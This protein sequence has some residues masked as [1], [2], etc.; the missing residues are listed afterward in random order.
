MDQTGIIAL[1]IITVSVCLNCLFALMIVLHRRR[2]VTLHNSELPRYPKV[3]IFL[4]LRNLDDGLEKNISSLLSSRYPAFDVFFA[5]D[6]MNEPC[7]PVIK[8]VIAQ[9]PGIHSTIVP[10]G[11]CESGNPKIHKLSRLEKM[12]DASLFW[13]L[14]SDIRVSPDTLASLVLE[15]LESGA[16]IVFCPIRCSGAATFGSLLEMSY[17]NFFLSGSIITVWKLFRQRVVVGKSMLI[18][19]RALGNFGGFTYFSDVLAEDHWL[20]EAFHKAGFIVRCNYTWVNNIKETTTIENFFGRISRW[21]KLRFCLAPRVYL[22]E[23]LFNP[24]GL[25]LL[26]VPL[27]KAL[28]IPVIGAIIL[29]RISAEYAVFFAVNSESGPRRAFL[30]RGLAPA[31]VCKD[32]MMLFVYVVPFFNRRVTWRGRKIKIRKDTR[33]I[34]KK[35]EA[36]FESLSDRNS[37]VVTVLMGLGHLR[38]AYPLLRMN[39]G[40]MIPY[41]SKFCTPS[42]EYG[43]WRDIRKSYYLISRAGEMPV[44]GKMLLRVLDM[45]QRIEPYHSF[46]DQRKPGFSARYLDY[47]IGRRGLCTGLVATLAELRGPVI[48]TYFAT[49]IAADKAFAH[50]PG[51]KNYLIICD[52]DFNRAWV[53]KDP[54]RSTLR[55]CVPCYW[56]RR[57]LIAYGVPE[58]NIYTT[59]FPLPVENIGSEDSLYILKSDVRERLRRLDPENRFFPVHEAD[60]SHWLGRTKAPLEHDAA[61]TVMFAVGG[62]GAQYRLAHTILDRLSGPV[63]KGKIRLIISTGIRKNIFASIM[64]RVHRL[65]LYDE[66]DKNL[67]LVFDTD[68]FGY[69]DKFNRCLRRTDVL[70]TKPSE[71]VFYAGLGIPVLMAPPIGAHEELNGKWL[72]KIHAGIEPLGPAE[73]CD[74]WLFDLRDS[75]SLAGAAWNGFLNARKLGAFKIERLVRGEP[76]EGGS[77]PLSR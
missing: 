47:L 39:I 51:K 22:L 9:F 32:L 50:D 5:V 69:F 11:H 62:A 40:K 38:A 68:P 36:G 24:L 52:S 46:K 48:H 34:V 64:N 10:T 56:A 15:N 37:G 19:S 4:T 23:I 61:L 73:F 16:H 28:S 57:R 75:G 17:V 35:P 77:T 30:L 45:V 7:V 8:R 60:V 70:W 76:D 20:G 33:I 13:I 18:D 71:L 6:S 58:E 74:R 43:I 53:P 1:T 55:Y 49:A 27:L 14:D 2:K 12:T 3:S 65:G 54:H 29:A 63:R 26:F 41:G 44:I 42:K 21:A 66:L 31:V 59:G 25:A 67:T 72:N